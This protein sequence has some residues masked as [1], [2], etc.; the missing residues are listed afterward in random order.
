MNRSA[1]A[2]NLYRGHH[3]W[4]G[5][6]E[7]SARFRQDLV[8]LPC[9]HLSHGI[10]DDPLFDREQAVRPNEARMGELSAFEVASVKRDGKT[11]GT[12]S[13][14]D[15]AENYVVTRK[16]D[17]HEGRSAF[18]DRKIRLRKWD[19]DDF[20]G[21][22]FAHAASSSGKFQSRASADSLR[23]AP[24]NGSSAILVFNRTAK[25]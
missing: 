10:E 6:S 1:A 2:Q 14:G 7:K 24:L 16:I 23:A 15:L 22:R 8:E 20:A 11:V 5:V 3:F 12:R 19:N 9:F 17:Q 13:R 18:P 25:S 4:R 21:Y